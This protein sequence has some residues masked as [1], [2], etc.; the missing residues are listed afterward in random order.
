MSS[1]KASERK[2]IHLSGTITQSRIAKAGTTLKS[3]L[4]VNSSVMARLFSVYVEMA[5]NVLRH[6]IPTECQ[7]TEL[8]ASGDVWIIESDNAYVIVTENP[9]RPEN[10]AAVQARL[11]ELTSLNAN[12]LRTLSRERL[13]QIPASGDRGAGIGLIEIARRASG[14]LMCEL[15]N[16]RSGNPLLRMTATIHKIKL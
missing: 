1:L 7:D 12:E 2:L 11:A 14:P 13:R 10:I 3:L 8:A 4:P 5:Q 6:S 9:S 16:D 15:K